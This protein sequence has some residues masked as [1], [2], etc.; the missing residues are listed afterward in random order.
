MTYTAQRIGSNGYTESVVHCASL[1]QL[2]EWAGVNGHIVVTG[3]DAKKAIVSGACV[4]MLDCN[5]RVSF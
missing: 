2:R 4:R 1:K 5:G 3:S